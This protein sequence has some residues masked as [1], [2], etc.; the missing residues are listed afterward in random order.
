MGEI[1]DQTQSRNK[2]WKKI[3][4]EKKEI[5][6]K[7][8]ERIWESGRNVEGKLEQ[9]LIDQLDTFQKLRNIHYLVRDVYTN[10]SKTIDNN[11]INR[12]EKNKK[13]QQI[14]TNFHSMEDL[15]NVIDTYIN[16]QQIQQQQQQ[17]QQPQQQTINIG[18]IKEIVVQPNSLD[19]KEIPKS[20]VLKCLIIIIDKNNQ[21]IALSSN[22]SLFN[23]RLNK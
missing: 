23:L 15:K 14:K 21:M 13:K 6:D 2:N 22:S 1:N 17:Q 8:R 19:I 18:N 16:Q 10:V 7:R 4:N 9:Q 12:Y 5:R 3:K 11:V 20:I